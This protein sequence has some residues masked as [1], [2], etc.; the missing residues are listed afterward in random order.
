MRLGR[1]ELHS[2]AL[3]PWRPANTTDDPVGVLPVLA[4]KLVLA[5]DTRS[6]LAVVRDEPAPA[7]RVLRSEH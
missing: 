2:A 7:E 6:D 5:G 4:L 1:L 3:A